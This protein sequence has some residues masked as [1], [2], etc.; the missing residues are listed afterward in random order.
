MPKHLEN[1]ITVEVR[2][3]NGEWKPLFHFI[4]LGGRIACRIADGEHLTAVAFNPLNNTWSEVKS[5][6]TGG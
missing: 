3:Q 1:V 2:R 5:G 4:A 6:P